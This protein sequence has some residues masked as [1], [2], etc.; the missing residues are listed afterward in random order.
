MKK[1]KNYDFL[2]IE[3]FSNE[4]NPITFRLFPS[5][6]FRS[7]NFR[8]SLVS[9]NSLRNNSTKNKVATTKLQRT[10]KKNLSFH[11]KNSEKKLYANNIK[12][13]K[14]LS[15]SVSKIPSSSPTIDD[16]K[17]AGSSSICYDHLPKNH[18]IEKK[19]ETPKES[20]FSKNL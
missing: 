3:R 6:Q 5:K 15:K 4:T 19:I 2:Q 14:P 7:F 17:M 16:V 13:S 18:S 9:K 11:V 8:T 20:N 12:L 1:I 10:N